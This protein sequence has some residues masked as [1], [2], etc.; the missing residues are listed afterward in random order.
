MISLG[1]TEALKRR[2]DIDNSAS[3]RRHRQSLLFS[4][5]LLAFACAALLLARR[6]QAWLAT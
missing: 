5:D 2:L 1:D 6:V 3:R 4:F